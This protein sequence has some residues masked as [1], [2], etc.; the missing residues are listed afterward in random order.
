MHIYTPFDLEKIKV[1][2]DI[3]EVKAEITS[4]SYTW[5]LKDSNNNTS[6]YFTI[7]TN[8]ESQ[9]EIIT[10]A[11][12]QTIY[13]Y[14]ELHN[15]QYMEVLIPYEVFFFAEN[16]DKIS[17]LSISKNRGLSIFANI[18][19]NTFNADISTIDPALLLSTLQLSLFE[20][21]K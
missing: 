12:V 4:N 1:I 17:C 6:I 21:I 8:I 14:Y 10:L 20:N 18:S 16:N 13:G 5:T 15:I 19:K 2:E 11:S 3:L 7:Y 9:D